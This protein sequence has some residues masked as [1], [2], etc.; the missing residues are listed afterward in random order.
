MC[1][2]SN[3]LS[4]SIMLSGN[5]ELNPKRVPEIATSAERSGFAGLWFGETTLHDASILATI[6]A[7]AST[8]IQLGTAILNVY[9]RTPSELALLGKTLNEYSNG[10]F[11]L[12]LGVSTAGIVKNW[13]GIQFEQPAARIVETVKILKLYYSGETFST[14]GKFSSPTN[15]RLKTSLP[16]KIALAALNDWMI[17]KAASISDRIILNVHP[18]ER[19]KHVTKIIEESCNGKNHPI[20]SVMLYSQIGE[21]AQNEDAARKL[22]SFYGSAPAYSSLFSSLGFHKEAKAMLEAWKR[23]DRDSAMRNV[24]R[25]MIDKLMV[26]GSVRDVKERVKMYIEAGVEDVFISPSP[27]GNFEENLNGVLTKF[28]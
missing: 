17:R 10:R 5:G 27:F 13:H 1:L 21:E 8:K 7:G 3:K 16:P 25:E 9:T 28:F 19:I 26:L 14:L 23:R 15:A 4:V 20:L 22:I 11:T 12:G 24:T 2:R 18:V 6:A